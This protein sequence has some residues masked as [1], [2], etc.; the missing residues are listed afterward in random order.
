MYIGGCVPTS[1]GEPVPGMVMKTREMDDKGEQHS[2]FVLF[3]STDGSTICDMPYTVL[4]THEYH[5]T[6][7]TRRPEPDR[8]GRRRTYRAF[9]P[10]A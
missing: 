8:R 4:P 6:Q 9:V 5:D 3:F 2:I 1:S 10:V 7:C